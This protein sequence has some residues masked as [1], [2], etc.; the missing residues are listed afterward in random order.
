MQNLNPHTDQK[1]KGVQYTVGSFLGGGKGQPQEE[2]YGFLTMN[3][4]HHEKSES[5]FKC[6]KKENSI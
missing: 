5:S 3:T 2:A 1:T 4:E 6:Y